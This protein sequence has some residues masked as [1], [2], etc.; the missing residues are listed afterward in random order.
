M[1]F[2]DFVNFMNSKLM[3]YS[4]YRIISLWPGNTSSNTNSAAN[5]LSYEYKSYL[6]L[7]IGSLRSK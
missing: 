5:G 3:N 2:V 4:D 7:L 6:E 1:S